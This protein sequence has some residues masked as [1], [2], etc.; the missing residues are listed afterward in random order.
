MRVRLFF[1]AEW[2]CLYINLENF[3][4]VRTWVNF[5]KL[6]FFYFF[7]K[8]MN[9]WEKNFEARK[10]NWFPT[11]C[12]SNI[13]KKSEFWKFINLWKKLFLFKKNFFINRYQYI[14]LNRQLLRTLP[15]CYRKLQTIRWSS[16]PSQTVRIATISRRKNRQDPLKYKVSFKTTF[17]LF[18]IQKSK[19]MKH[20]LKN[21]VN[22]SHSGNRN[23]RISV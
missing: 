23:S 11:F 12:P 4:K 13:F 1:E 5:Q 20:F 3:W 9:R 22:F 15:I 19:R 10:N 8:N 21:E 18:F 2:N 7:L 17:L 14:F 6:V 16:C